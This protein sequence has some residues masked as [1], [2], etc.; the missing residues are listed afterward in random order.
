M[1]I[2][3]GIGM[4]QFRPKLQLTALIS[5]VHS[6]N[7]VSWLFHMG[8]MHWAGWG[9]M[10]L[11]YRGG[12]RKKPKVVPGTNSINLC[13]SWKT[14]AQYFEGMIEQTIKVKMTVAEFQY[15]G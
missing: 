5:N 9:N 11:L 13:C 1:G 14:H 6:A 4:G 12:N 10:S 3:G 7:G 15:W 2:H 8:T